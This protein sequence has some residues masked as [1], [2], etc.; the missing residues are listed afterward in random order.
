MA[1][2]ACRFW[3]YAGAT[4]VV[5]RAV[6]MTCTCRITA[7]EAAIASMNAPISQTMR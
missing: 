2:R 7:V 1:C 3:S 5:I 4:T 6:L